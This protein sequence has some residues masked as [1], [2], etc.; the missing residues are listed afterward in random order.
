MIAEI[1]PSAYDATGRQVSHPFHRRKGPHP[2]F[3]IGR[4]VSQPLTVHC[5]SL[6]ELRTFL[7]KCRYISD[8]KLF[9]KEEYWQPPEEFEKLKAGDCEDFALWTW[10]QMLAMGLDSR[11]VF[12]KHGRYGTGHAWVMFSQDGRF[13]LVEPQARF[14][15]LRLPR[16]STLG[17]EPRFSVAWDGE[18]LRYYAHKTDSDSH[19]H[20]GR[21]VTLIPEWI[22]I[23]GIFWCRTLPLLPHAIGRAIWRKIKTL[24][25]TKQT[26]SI[27]L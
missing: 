25:G 1:I 4:F 3:P 5:A 11:I 23:S 22:V 6:T 7:C 24:V 16:L 15:G 2:T 27:R 17:Y 12:G 14:R 8:E 9:G 13:Y 10:R 19:L 21:I 20:W 18:T 26:N